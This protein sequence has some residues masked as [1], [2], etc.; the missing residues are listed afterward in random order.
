MGLLE[1]CETLFGTDDLFK[2]L[3]LSRDANESK[4][5]KAYYKMSL[6]VH[7]D[8]S[9]EDNQSFKK[10]KSNPRLE[11]WR[12]RTKATKKGFTFQRMGIMAEIRRLKAFSIKSA[13]QVFTNIE[14]KHNKSLIAC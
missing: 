8:K 13:L 6:K 7:P 9:N 14:Q 1:D 12:E 3:S 10:A 2:V 5:K 4:I 11:R